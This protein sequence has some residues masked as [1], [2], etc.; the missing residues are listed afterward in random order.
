MTTPVD[1]GTRYL[2]LA[3]QAPWVAS[4]SPLT[5]NLDDL[6]RLEDAGAAAVVLPSLFEEEI[7]H[8]ALELDRMLAVGS[9][10]FGEAT[11]YFPTL[12]DRDVG[13]DRYLDL[14]AAAKQSLGIPVIASLNGATPGGWLDYARDIEAAGADGLELNLYFV[15]ADPTQTAAEIE[16]R[17]RAIVAQVRDS[18]GLPISV[19]LSPFFTSL[20]HTARELV[21]AG[22]NGLTL[23]NRFDQPDLDIERLEVV[24]RLVLSHSYELLLPLRW[25]GI[26]RSRIDASIAAST[27]VHCAE[28]VLKVI[29]AG[30]DVAMV[31][32]GALERGP[33]VFAEIARG[34]RTWMEEREYASVAQMRGSV[35]QHAVADP[36]AYERGNYV[37]TLRSWSSR[38]GG[39]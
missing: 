1:L 38:I 7:S 28:D 31:A 21:A 25:V 8:H 2:G 39:V 11:S 29:L 23:F 24:P 26:L 10:S 36:A 19:K 6:R 9:D 5:G 37:R 34:V 27:G 17:D 16:A 18:I 32:S 35:G 15:A 14:I 4:S 3:L 30:A 20:A 12:E 33:A 13:P 22:A